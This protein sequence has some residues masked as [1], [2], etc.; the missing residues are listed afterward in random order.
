M[1]SAAL[2]E[3]FGQRQQTFRLGQHIVGRHFAA[4]PGTHLPGYRR[5]LAAQVFYLLSTVKPMPIQ[6][7]RRRHNSTFRLIRFIVYSKVCSIR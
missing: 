2:G 3:R 4:S 7:H 1:W 5:H 6:A